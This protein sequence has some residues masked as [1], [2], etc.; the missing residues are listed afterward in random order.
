MSRSTSRPDERR[1]HRSALIIFS[2]DALKNAAVPLILIVGGTLFGGSLD[3]RDLLRAAIWGGAGLAIA[4]TVGVIR[5]Q[6]TSYYIGPEAIHH[7]TGALSKKVTDIRLDRIEAIDIHQGPLQRL[8][9]VY[10]GRRPDGGGQE[11]RRDL[12]AGAHTRGGRGA[13]RGA[14][15]G[16]APRR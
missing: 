1:L 12:A 2:A 13:A 3:T 7:L 16:G 4:V 11:G 15:A 6:S 5:Y 9:G 8:F 10:A 14:P